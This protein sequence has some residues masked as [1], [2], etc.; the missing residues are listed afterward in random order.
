MTI[1]Y[2]ITPN[3]ILNYCIAGKDNF[4]VF[5]FAV[6]RLIEFFARQGVECY[7]TDFDFYLAFLLPL[8]CGFHNC[9]MYPDLHQEFLGNLKILIVSEDTLEAASLYH[10]N[11]TDAVRLAVA[12]EN[13]LDG[14]I[15]WEPSHFAQKMR[16]KITLDREHQAD[17]FVAHSRDE[18][19]G[20]LTEVT[21]FVSSVKAF[22]PRQA[23]L[24]E[25]IYSEANIRGSIQH[26]QLRNIEIAVY[27]CNP[28]EPHIN[29]SVYLERDGDVRCHSSTGV[30]VICTLFDAIKNCAS[31]LLDCPPYD[32][33]YYYGP[34]SGR[35]NGLAQI[36]VLIHQGDRYFQG[37]G[38]GNDLLV[39]SAKAYIDAINHLLSDSQFS[40]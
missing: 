29:L 10:I 3:V 8:L 14:I 6:K 17:I 4:R 13:A 18:E 9:R 15:T 22:L 25:S 11:P 19:T 21:M 28:I 35:I 37:I 16:D 24:T 31:Q 40:F 23:Q 20:Q 34:I 33:V 39:A 26:L 7:M 38:L 30:G 36:Q 1:R 2:L 12:V 27:S 32:Y 5:R